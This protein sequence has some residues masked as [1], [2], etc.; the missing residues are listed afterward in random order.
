MGKV[1]L[2]IGAVILVL[3]AS[4]VLLLV[5]SNK[6]KMTTTQATTQERQN[7]TQP[8]QAATT[9]PINSIKG[10]IPLSVSEPQDGSISQV[11]VIKVKGTT[12]PN[13]EVYVND[14][15]TKADANGSFTVSLALDE[16]DNYILVAAADPIGR[17]SEKELTVSYQPPQ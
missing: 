13:A 16:G 7:Q 14:S 17:Y 2:F 6:N 5:T 3:I 15:Q 8:G 11:S 10:E 12:A 4:T 9:S 1:Y